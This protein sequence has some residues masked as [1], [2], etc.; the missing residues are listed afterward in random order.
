MNFSYDITLPAAR[1]VLVFTEVHLRRGSR[2]GHRPSFAGGIY[3]GN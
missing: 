2:E 3:G 1:E